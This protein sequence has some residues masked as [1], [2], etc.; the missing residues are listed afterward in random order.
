MPFTFQIGPL[1][2]AADRALAVALIMVFLILA[3]VIAKKKDRAA[4]R[5][6]WWALG[7]GVV[8]ARAGFVAGNWDAFAAELVSILAIWQGGFSLAAGAAGAVAAIVLMMG[9][10]RSAV[11]LA[12]AVALLGGA[13]LGVSPL[14]RPDP[15]PLPAHVPIE[16]WS[17]ETIALSQFRGQP[18]VVNLWASWCLPCRREMPMLVDAASR[19]PVPILLVNSGEERVSAEQFLRANRLPSRSVY[20]D[21][22]AALGA[23]TGAGGY[24][25]TLFVN[26]AGQIETVHLGE[27]SRAMLATELRKL[28]REVR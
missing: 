21:P 18:F 7:A 16:R 8:A 10:S 5:A 12:G 17:G 13:Y 24:P 6:G 9:L 26:S 1:M 27:I 4:E 22:T 19:S 3:G 20:L 2:L 23:A 15:Q 11:A 14:L 25:A 28:E